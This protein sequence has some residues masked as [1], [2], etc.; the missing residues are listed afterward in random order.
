VKPLPSV[1]R[2]FIGPAIVLSFSLAQP[3]Q[4]PIVTLISFVAA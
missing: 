3:P 4:P 2:I 1:A